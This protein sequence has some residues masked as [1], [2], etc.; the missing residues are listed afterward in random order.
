VARCAQLD[1]GEARPDSREPASELLPIGDPLGRHATRLPPSALRPLTNAFQRTDRAGDGTVER[2]T[3]RLEFRL[4]GPLEVRDGDRTL[5]VGGAKQRSV[6][7]ILLLH[8]GEAVSVD[9]LVDEVW[10]DSPPEDAGTAL[11][12][13]ISRLRKA[14]EPHSALATRS[15]GYVVEVSEGQLDLHRFE[16]LRDEG[17]RLLDAGRP[18]EA[19]DALR[20]ALALWRGRPLADLEN[21]PFAAEAIARL[22]EAWI[23]A[24]ELRIEADLALGRH[25]A[26]AAELRTLVKRHPLRERLRGQLMLALYRAG[27]QA[28]ALDVYADARRTFADEL[29]LEPGPALRQLQEAVL[30]QDP[31]LELPTAR[32]RPPRA[33]VRPRTAAALLA[34]GLAI[35]A[36]L[37]IIVRDDE[38]AGMQSAAPGGALVAIDAATGRVERRVGAGRAPASV[39]VGADERVWAV[40]ADARTLLAVDPSSGEVEALATGATPTEVAVGAGGV[41]VVNGRPTSTAQFVGPIATQV[42]AVDPTTRSQRAVVQL[43][44]ARGTVS[45]AVGQRL[46]VSSRAVWAATAAGAVARIDPARPRS[47]GRLRTSER[48]PSPRAQPACGRCAET[49]S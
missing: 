2:L 19:A 17:R 41:W 9:R 44:R 3:G 10:G 1:I 49:A 12:Q 8:A 37:V 30:K 14:L 43:P 6:L 27:R 16:L 39:A 7:A 13:H 34:A 4:L 40:D 38:G 5:P 33:S 20:Q 18:E 21:E 24:V 46:A 26:L 45:N 15:P 35:T 47:R 31:S 48:S 23:E 11:Q 32:P 28:E 29:G 36:G 25:S 42:V 22:D